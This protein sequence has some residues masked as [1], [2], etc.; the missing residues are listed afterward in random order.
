[1]SKTAADQLACD[2]QLLPEWRRK[3]ACAYRRPIDQLLCVKAY[4]LLQQLLKD[5][6]NITRQPEFT[7][8]AKGKPQLKH[9]PDI[10]FNLSHCP[11]GALCAIG[12]EP[13][14]C[15]IESIDNK[16]DMDIL[17]RCCSLQ[18][19]TMILNSDHQEESFT[20]LWTKKE[21]FLKLS[22]EG[23]CEDL[24]GLLESKE[25]GKVTFETQINRIHG[26]VY[27]VCRYSNP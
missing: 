8:A 4:I 11:K 17:N 7:F 27:T 12:N 22:G 14:G 24:P 18:E 19:R 2:L 21:A 15:D 25:A 9:F 10:H 26:Y 6:Y 20:V 5:E 3:K 23:L 1:M 16:I 13:V